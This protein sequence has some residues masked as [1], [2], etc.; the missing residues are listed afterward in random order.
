MGERGESM[1][2]A[3]VLKFPGRVNGPESAGF[4]PFRVLVSSV[5]WYCR[6]VLRGVPG[7]GCP[8]Y[9]GQ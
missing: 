8:L 4:A 9:R 3:D 2:P 6:Q 1:I 7:I 5:G